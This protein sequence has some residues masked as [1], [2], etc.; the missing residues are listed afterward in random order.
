MIFYRV[1]LTLIF[2]SS[3]GAAQQGIPTMTLKV[4]ADALVVSG[5]IDHN[6]F[7]EFLSAIEVSLPSRIIFRNVIGGSPRAVNLFSG[8]ISTMNI[9]TQI[10]GN[11]FSA[12]ALVYMAGSKRTVTTRR[13]TI[14]FHGPR[15]PNGETRSDCPPDP[16][17][18]LAQVQIGSRA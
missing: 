3:I 8:K 7:A 13:S 2:I 17:P 14:A 10:D 4:E 1:P 18:R 12:C 5:Y 9:E 15:G 6:R 16:R 11:C